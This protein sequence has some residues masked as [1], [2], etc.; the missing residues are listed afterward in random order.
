MEF[1][2]T[3]YN[4]GSRRTV[5]Q[6][7]KGMV[8]TSQPLASQ[9]GLDILKKGGNAVD[10]AV[11]TAACLTVVEPT[12]NGIG[13][14]AFAIISFEGKLIGL[15][16]SGPSPELLSLNELKKRE[17]YEIPKFGLTPVT[18]PGV[19]K[20]WAELIEKYGKLSLIEVLEPAIRYA[21][22]GYPISAT[23]SQLWNK[24][25]EKFKKETEGK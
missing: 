14:D 20:A 25:Y 18:V 5:V 2:N 6:G 1:N 3:T 11:A 24:G 13:G 16:A 23:V 10:S 21:E 8:A 9:A 7:K 15:N 4:Y 19:P 12:S 22:E 17:L